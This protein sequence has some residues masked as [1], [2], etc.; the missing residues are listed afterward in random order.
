MDLLYILFFFIVITV[1]FLPLF[2][3]LKFPEPIWNWDKIELKNISFPKSFIWGTATAAH[4]VEG[5]CQNNWSEFETGRKSNGIP[6]IKDA[7]ISGNACEHWSRYRQDI[8]LIVETGVSHYRFSIEWSKIEPTKGSFNQDAINHYQ[9]VI[10]ELIT[11]GITPVITLHHFSHPVWFEDIGGFEK[12]ENIDHFVN[13]SITVFN[14]YSDKVKNW[15]T[16]NE[17]AVFAVQGYFTGMFPPG[18]KNSKLTGQ[19]LKN[20]LESHVQVYHALKKQSGG[21]DAKIGIVKNINQFDPW[22]RY[23]I[24]DWLFVIALNHVF[25]WSSIKFFKTGI[26][27]IRLPGLMWITHKN[28]MAT[29]SNDFF[30]LNY[31]SH[32]HIKF[33]PFKPDFSELKYHKNDTMTDMPYTIYAEGIYRAIKLVSQLNKPIIITE[34]GV[35]DKNDSFRSTYITKYLYAVRKAIADGYDITGYYYWSLMDNFEWAFGYDMKF[36]LYQ[37]DFESQKRKLR[38]GAKSYIKIV[39]NNEK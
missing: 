23:L 16:I 26:F 35:A 29:D 36:G 32:N 24:F 34:N 5:D 12:E 6:N 31:Y 28:L 19:V 38:E 25:N 37:V 2:F 7:Q 30:G 39:K 10:D 9:N 20:L 22:R 15:C 8:K 17:P 13:F 1:F 4:Q 27:K 14:L 11:S 3:H 18:K 33:N 21:K